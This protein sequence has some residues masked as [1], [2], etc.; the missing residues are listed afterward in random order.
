LRRTLE[1]LDIC[2]SVFGKF[3]VKAALGEL[4]FDRPEQLL[5]LLSQMAKNRVID[6]H[7]RESVRPTGKAS[8][9]QDDVQAVQVQSPSQ[10]IEHQDLMQKMSQL[11]SE[12]ERQI[13]GLRR[14][15]ESWASIASQV[16]GTAESVR[17]ILSRASQRIMDELEIPA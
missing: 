2:Q 17:K 6:H 8:A 15:G 9:L 5:R 14:N 7:R 10:L 3:F 11:M 4:E 16:G 12:S 13:A 1:S